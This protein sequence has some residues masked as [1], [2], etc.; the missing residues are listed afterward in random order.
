[1]ICAAAKQDD[2]IC[3]ISEISGFNAP[4][5]QFL[6]LASN[7]ESSVEIHIY[8]PPVISTVD[9]T[10]EVSQIK[11]PAM[12]G[13]NSQY[14]NFNQGSDAE[15]EKA[16]QKLIDAIIAAKPTA[17]PI[18]VLSLQLGE[19]VFTPGLDES[20]HEFITPI[21]APAPP[22]AIDSVPLPEPE[23]EPQP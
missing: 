13:V 11:I 1:M 3:L 20:M 17:K 12:H 19:A 10:P 14:I 4:A 8:S 9:D 7:T 21:E 22:A 15:N 5:P 23:P 6:Y 16:R 18:S 2:A